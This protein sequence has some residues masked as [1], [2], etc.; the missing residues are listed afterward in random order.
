[1]RGFGVRMRAR[2]HGGRNERAEE[3]RGLEVRCK[4]SPVVRGRRDKEL[5]DIFCAALKCRESGREYSECLLE[6]VRPEA[7]SIHNRNELPW[8]Q[9]TYLISVAN[10]G[11]KKF[12]VN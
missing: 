10:D 8:H 11:C 4:G 1:M 5:K 9:H 12:G 6:P 2:R 7:D 3:D